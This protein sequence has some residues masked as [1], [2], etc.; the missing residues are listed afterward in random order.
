M[1]SGE[2]A[3]CIRS[4]SVGLNY[5]LIGITIFRAWAFRMYLS[6]HPTPLGEAASTLFQTYNARS[7]YEIWTIYRGLVEIR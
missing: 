2:F 1:S 4:G 3:I 6:S 5:V 7:K